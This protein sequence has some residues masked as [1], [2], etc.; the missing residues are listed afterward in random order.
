[1]ENEILKEALDVACQKKD[2]ALA[3]LER[4][5]RRSTVSAVAR[6]LDVACSQINERRGRAVKPRDPYR[7]AEDAAEAVQIGRYVYKIM[8]VSALR[9]L[10]RIPSSRSQEPPARTPVSETTA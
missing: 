2:I 4:S 3:V 1:M 8:R 9:P 6:T 10:L 5:R 7:K